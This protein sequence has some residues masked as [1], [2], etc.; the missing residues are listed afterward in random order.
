[1]EREERAEKKEKKV[2]GE[3]GKGRT[4]K[5]RNKWKRSR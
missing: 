3:E 2:E 5:W 1:M 4:K